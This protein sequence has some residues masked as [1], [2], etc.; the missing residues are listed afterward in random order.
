MHPTRIFK[1]PE[2]LYEAFER[3]KKDVDERASEW[4]VVK[5]VG[6]DADRVTDGQKLPLTLDGF[7]VFC[8][9]AKIGYI[10]Q[11]FINAGDRYNDFIGICRDIKLEIRDNQIT[12]G[13]LG[14]FN[15]S[16]TQRLNGLTEKQEVVTTGNYTINT[17]PEAEGLG[18]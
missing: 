16:I 12:G 17:I 11:Y 13:M 9:K 15:P 3:Y 1:T 18:E 7:Y 8:R 5:Y 10:E 6:K 4:L 2:E 14:F